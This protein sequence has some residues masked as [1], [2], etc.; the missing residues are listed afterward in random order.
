MEVEEASRNRVKGIKKFS[1]HKLHMTGKILH[2]DADKDYL[3][4]CLK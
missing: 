1:R 4:K 2:I 3:E